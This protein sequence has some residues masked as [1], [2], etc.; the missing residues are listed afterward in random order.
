ME[1]TTCKDCR[2]WISGPFRAGLDVAVGECHRHAPR[3][4]AYSTGQ[5]L[6]QFQW[7]EIRGNDWCGEWEQREKDES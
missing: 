6:Q 7:L 2:F 3:P 4:S 1:N 5:G